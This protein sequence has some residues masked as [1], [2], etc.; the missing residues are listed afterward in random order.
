MSSFLYESGLHILQYSGLLLWIHFFW[1][2]KWQS[3][4]LFFLCLHNWFPP[5]SKQYSILILCLHIDFQLLLNNFWICIFFFFDIFNL[6]VFFGFSFLIFSKILFISTHFCSSILQILHC[7]FDIDLLWIQIETHLFEMFL[8][9]L[10]FFEILKLF[11]GYL[12]FKIFNF[13]SNLL[14]SIF[15]FFFKL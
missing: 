4:H 5:Q 14:F 10:L 8:C 12:F 11:F 7:F 3:L 2:L 13:S 6:Y 9:N 1:I 15:Y